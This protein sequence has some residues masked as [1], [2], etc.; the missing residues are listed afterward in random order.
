METGTLNRIPEDQL[1][2]RYQLIMQYLFLAAVLGILGS[3]PILLSV[4]IRKQP[5]SMITRALLAFLVLAPVPFLL[6][7]FLASFEP[8]VHWGWRLG[9]GVFLLWSLITAARLCWVKRRPSVDTHSPQ[10]QQATDKSLD[11]KQ[12]IDS[13]NSEIERA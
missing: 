13:E 12:E 5:L 7:G 8:G 4:A 1:V 3:F 9:Y 2:R 10:V 11:R 6:F